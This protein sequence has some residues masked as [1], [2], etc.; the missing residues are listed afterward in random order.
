MLPDLGN[1][2]YALDNLYFNGRLKSAAIH[3]IVL[4]V[5]SSTY[6]FYLFEEIIC[7]K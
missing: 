7:F 2:P 6:S 1:I 5:V 4:V 3:K